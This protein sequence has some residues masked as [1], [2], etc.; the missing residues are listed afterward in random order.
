MDL[1]MRPLMVHAVRI[2]LDGFSGDRL[3]KQ[4]VQALCNIGQTRLTEKLTTP[5]LQCIQE[6][7]KLVVRCWIVRPCLTKLLS[8]IG[9]FGMASLPGVDAMES[10]ILSRTLTSAS[11]IHR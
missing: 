3:A 10:I 8:R 4:A 7:D 6:L 2:R 9:W 5:L 1:L 11:V